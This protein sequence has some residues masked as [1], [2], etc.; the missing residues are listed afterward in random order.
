MLT[1]WIFILRYKINFYNKFK[2]FPK[3]SKI[4][5]YLY[6]KLLKID[7]KDDKI[8]N[9]DKKVLG[10]IFYSFFNNDFS[11][12]SRYYQQFINL[13]NNNKF[14][15]VVKSLR[16]FPS[17]H[18]FILLTE[19]KKNAG[20]LMNY[21]K[22]N[23]IYCSN[24]YPLL[25]NDLKYLENSKKIDKCVIEIPIENNSKKMEYLFNKLDQFCC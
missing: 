23:K 25:T 11:F 10:G 15:N 17:V 12:R 1:T 7:I 24:G 4:K 16:G 3:I 9:F 18:K 13:F 22:K 20:Q 14:F 2:I 19:S 21:L 6:D 8:T 5:N